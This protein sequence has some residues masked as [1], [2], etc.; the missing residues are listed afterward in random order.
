[1]GF[2]GS[3]HYYAVAVKWKKRKAEWEIWVLPKKRK[4]RH[5]RGR[6][7]R[8]LLLTKAELAEKREEAAGMDGYIYIWR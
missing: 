1:M 2:S 8:K 3:L 4:R 7:H 6:F 5:A